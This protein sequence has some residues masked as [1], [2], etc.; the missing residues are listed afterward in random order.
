MYRTVSFSEISV[1]VV[2]GCF[3]DRSSG[4]M[5]LSLS[6][7]STAVCLSRGQRREAARKQFKEGK[8]SLCS[9]C[10]F[11]EGIYVLCVYVCHSLFVCM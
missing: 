10:D 7:S 1:S 2:R 4:F 8:L 3:K 5:L 6:V 9:C 11:C